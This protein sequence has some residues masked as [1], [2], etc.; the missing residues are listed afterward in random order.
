[1]SL[2]NDR[3]HI[4]EK[5]I[6]ASI[7]GTIWAAS[8]IVLGSFLHNLKIPF[9]GNILTGIGLIVLISVS[10][11]WKERGLFW[12]AGVICSLLKTLS[13]SAFIFGPMIAIITESMLLE[14]SVRVIGRNALGFITGSMLAMSWNLFQKAANLIIFYGNNFIDLYGNMVSYAEKQL[15]VHFD[16]FWM[17]LLILL[18]LY[19]LFGAFVAVIGIRTG[20][21]LT[22]RHYIIAENKKADNLLTKPGG[23][24]E[25]SYSVF[26]LFTDILL[27]IF[28]MILVG[29]AGWYLYIP[30]VTLVTII[31]AI[32]YKRALRQISRPRFWVLFVLLTMI[33]AFFFTAVQSEGK[34][35]YGG[36]MTGLQMN[37][38]AVVV[39]TGFTVLGTELY[40]PRIRM[41]FMKTHLKQLPLA[42]ELSAESLPSIIAG[43]PD[44][45]TLLRNPVSA[46]AAMISGVEARLEEVR[47]ATQSGGRVFFLTGESRDGKTT[48]IEGLVKRMDKRGLKSAGLYSPRV[49][50]M[51]DTIGYD[52]VDILDGTRVPF[53]RVT[54]EKTA[55]SIGRFSIIGEG[56]EK[57]LGALDPL[58]TVNCSLVIID[59]AGPLEMRGGGWYNGIRRLLTERNVNVLLVVRESLLNEMIREWDITDAKVFDITAEG[60]EAIQERILSNIG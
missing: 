20:K 25:F 29:R 30:S 54:D 4:S 17:P 28:L 37:F 1:M 55:E 47:K 48:L 14:F 21:K 50:S 57:G 24:S 12:R 36:I 7:T 49:M 5:W 60:T 44:A 23:K 8:E 41:L 26:W 32:R 35:Y 11:I 46:L 43:L 27:M 16:L 33:T 6:K 45:K 22:L 56:L 51:D 38:R 19:C 34:D 2:M 52:V 53:L 3:S 42:L 13:P 39:I 18:L 58:R 40:N 59:E 10:F 31:W 9:S 15:N